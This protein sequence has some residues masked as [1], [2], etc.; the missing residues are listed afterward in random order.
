MKTQLQKH[1]SVFAHCRSLFVF[2]AGLLTLM[3]K[4]ELQGG[5]C[6]DC[7]VVMYLAVIPFPIRRKLCFNDRKEPFLLSAFLW[8][9]VG[10]S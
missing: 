3:S 9:T 8:R 4:T 7:D 10:I 1:T 6:V 2:L 5:C